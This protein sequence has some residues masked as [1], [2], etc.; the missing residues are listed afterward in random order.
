MKKK[1]LFYS[2]V[3]NLSLFVTQKF[4]KTDID[5]LTDLGFEV[6]VSNKISD[7]LSFWKYDIAFIYFYKYGFFV[8]A[9]ARLFGKKVYFTGGID[10]LDEAYSSPKKYRIQKLFFKLCHCMS[11]K[12]ILVSTSDMDNIKKIYKG[13]LP[14]KTATSFHAI[15]VESFLCS[16]AQDKSTD[17]STIVWMGGKENVI[18]KGVDKSLELFKLLVDNYPDYS[19]SKFIIIGKKGD[20]TAYLE[21]LV[22][23]LNLYDKVEFT[24]EID[25]DVKIDLL[26]R[27]KIYMQLSKYEGFGV[28]AAEA[29]AAQNIVINSG[30]GGLKD[31]VGAFGIYVN[32]DEDIAKQ[33]Q[34]IHE[35]IQKVDA[36]FLK[37]GEQYVVDNFSYYI[38]K[39]DFE[40]ILMT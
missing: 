10:D 30:K 38:R 39:N 7:F 14:K 40:K 25:E 28:A 35:Q 36:A 3:T 33:Y 4:Y 13:R 34:M 20:G 5:I 27:S 15:Q 23:D 32:I 26:K 1:V 24:D 29:L 18:R 16:D 17:F 22:N 37:L 31:S 8:S 6:N 11:T 12:C 19:D 2:S 21:K 9:I